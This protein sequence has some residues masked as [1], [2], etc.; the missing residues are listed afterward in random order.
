ML[1]WLDATSE[2]TYI[3]DLRDVTTDIR[4][5]YISGETKNLQL[6]PSF[7]Q[8]DHMYVRVI[9]QNQFDFLMA[10]FKLKSFWVYGLRVADFSALETQ[11]E[12]ETLVLQWNTKATE[13]WDLS[14]HP[15]LKKIALHDF[16]KLRLITNL[17]L[18]PSL[19]YVE[20]SGGIWNALTLE[21]LEPI[22]LLTNLRELSM[23][24]I[25]VKDESLAPLTA[26]E[27]LRTLSI[28]NQFRTE[29]YAMLSVKMPNVTCDLFVPY[30]RLEQ[31]IDGKDVMVIGKR[32]PFLSSVSDQARL[33][34]VE[35]QFRELQKNFEQ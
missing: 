11:T 20:L 35:Q 32:K 24:N 25:R 26:L 22:R 30:V 34:K 21:T 14:N 3:E 10:Q 4:T 6:L 9:N 31:P 16:S 2:L 27:S 5:L 18:C 28:S 13:L 7:N 33:Q 1:D 8:V 12:L 17:G 23:S 15:R 19:E 29:E